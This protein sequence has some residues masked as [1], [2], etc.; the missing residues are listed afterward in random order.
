MYVQ[1]E[2]TLFDEENDKTKGAGYFK[3]SSKHNGSA[4]G[5]V[6]TRR[7]GKMATNAMA[8]LH[9]SL[10]HSPPTSTVNER[11]KAQVLLQ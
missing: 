3:Q 10:P 2:K 6:V 1:Q 9:H 11:G 7:V 5:T 4:A 8:G